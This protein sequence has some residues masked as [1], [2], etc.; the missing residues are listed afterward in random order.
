MTPEQI[1]ELHPWAKKFGRQLGK[2]VRDD[3]NAKYGSRDGEEPIHLSEVEYI[4]EYKLKITFNNA[5]IRTIDFHKFLFEDCSFYYKELRDLEQFKKAFVECDLLVRE[6]SY[7][8][9]NGPGHYYWNY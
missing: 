9:L 8:E 4:E 1:A 2:K 7:I 6:P 3:R 5:V